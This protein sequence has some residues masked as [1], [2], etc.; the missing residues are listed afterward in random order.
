MEGTVELDSDYPSSCN[1]ELMNY[2]ERDEWSISFS[3]LSDHIFPSTNLSPFDEVNSMERGYDDKVSF[4]GDAMALQEMDMDGVNYP[5]GK[6]RYVERSVISRPLGPSLDEKLLKALHLCIRSFRGGALAQVWVPLRNG[7]E[8]ILST[9]GQPYLHDGRLSEYREIS[10]LFSFAAEPGASSLLGLPGRVFTSKAPE[11]TSNL[12]YYNKAEYLRV[13]HAVHHKVR[14]SIALP[15]FEDCSDERS[16]CAVLEIVTTEEKSNFDSEMEYVSRALQAVDLSSRQSSRLSPQSLSSNQRAALAEIKDILFAICR[17]HRLPLALTW[18]PNETAQVLFLEESTCY[19]TDERM[20]GFVHACTNHFLEEGKGLVGK[21]LKSNRPFFY[22][23]VKEFHVSEYPLVH[24]ARKLGLSAAVAIRLRSSYTAEDDYVVEFFLPV[25]TKGDNEKLLLV[26]S[27][28]ANVETIC[29]SLSKVSELVEETKPEQLVINDELHSTKRYS[30]QTEKKR[31]TSEKNIS[32]NVLQKYFSENLKHAASSLGVC[33]TTLKRIC[34]QHGIARWPFRKI[35]KVDRSLKKIRGMLESVP[36]VDLD[37]GRNL[38]LTGRTSLS[39]QSD[40]VVETTAGCVVIDVEREEE[41]LVD[42]EDV[43]NCDGSKLAVLDMSP[44]W[45]ASLNT[46]PWMTPSMDPHDPFLPQA[47]NSGW[48]ACSSDEIN[49]KQ[50]SSDVTNSL[51]VSE[52]VPMMN[53]SSSSSGSLDETTNVRRD[54]AI[55]TVKATDGENTVRFKFEPS[56][57]CF[58]LYSEV[59]KRFELG[60]GEF[61]LRYL[62]DDEEWVLLVSDSDL[63][64][65]VEVLELLH[66]R[67]VKFRVSRVEELRYKI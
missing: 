63:V 18:I 65:C 57:G 48:K 38:L 25:D 59:A 60:T 40:V 64:E 8:C 3:N 58:E 16:C 66:T 67:T 50:A 49:K 31:N 1:V 9:A 11:W 45:P 27:L 26:R 30:K 17:S 61:Q 2:E 14:G 56:A 62:D 7:D 41:C 42:M 23:D 39:A 5:N 51:Y 55:I 47:R 53:V 43:L 37:C 44:S 15:V 29:T 33:P 32:L 20:E 21:A 52:S 6:K 4:E 24:H 46:M 54:S 36:G 19:S 34:R 12:M 22:P 13:Q 35:K 10:R 28:L